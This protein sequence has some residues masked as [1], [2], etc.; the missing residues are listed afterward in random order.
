MVLSS[1]LLRLQAVVEGKHK[2]DWKYK[3]AKFDLI[4]HFKDVVKKKFLSKILFD[5]LANKKRNCFL[6]IILG[7]R[8]KQ[9]ESVD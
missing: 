3:L 7:V 8:N 6:L 4:R 5:T 9:I 1:G 2:A